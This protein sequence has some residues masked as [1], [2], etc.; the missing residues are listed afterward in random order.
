MKKSRIFLLIAILFMLIVFYVVYDMSTKTKFRKFGSDT[1][2][3]KSVKDSVKQKD[4]MEVE[5][6][7]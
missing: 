5:I 3:N 1:E 4:P 6:R 2:E 7:R